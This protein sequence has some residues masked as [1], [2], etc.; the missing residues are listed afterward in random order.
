MNI[1][2]KVDGLPVLGI[3]GYSF[4]NDDTI[5]SITVPSSVVAIVEKAFAEC[6][7]VTKITIPKS[8]EYI[9]ATAFDGSK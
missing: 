1:P 8:V 2:S 5:T 3:L 7:Q 4:Y 9:D 6:T